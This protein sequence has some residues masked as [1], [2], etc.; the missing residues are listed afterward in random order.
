MLAAMFD[1]EL[2]LPRDFD[3]V[4]EAATRS[5]VINWAN[6]NETILTKRKLKE[7]SDPKAELGDEG[8]CFAVALLNNRTLKRRLGAKVMISPLVI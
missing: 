8:V 3:D 4:Q 5:S 2:V 7:L 6:N 1:E